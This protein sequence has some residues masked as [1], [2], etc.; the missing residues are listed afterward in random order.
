ML[1]VGAN[2]SSN[3]LCQSGFG[4]SEYNACSIGK[5]KTTVS[6]H[7][8]VSCPPG[9]T[10]LHPG[11]AAESDCVV[12]SGHYGNGTAGF[13]PCPAGS[14]APSPS[15][16]HCLLCAAGATGPE[17]AQS[18]AECGCNQLGQQARP[19]CVEM[20]QTQ[21][22]LQQRGQRLGKQRRSFCQGC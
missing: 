15:M 21:L 16:Q 14:Y 5:Y 6:M 2:H 3:C 22:T 8:C 11:S 4:G 17:G 20:L 9:V 7:E 10:T 1:T 13:L 18:N 12:A 19:A